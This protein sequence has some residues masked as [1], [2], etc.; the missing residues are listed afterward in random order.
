[1][2]LSVHTMSTPHL[3]LLKAIEL[4]A[5]IG[6]D[7]ID[8]ICDNDYRCA[9]TREPSFNRLKEIKRQTGYYGI[10]VVALTPYIKEINVADKKRRETAIAELQKCIDIAAEFDCKSIRI[11][12]GIEPEKNEWED[13]VNRLVESLQQL[14]EYAAKT[15]LSLNIENHSGSMAMTAHQTVQIVT[16]V[17]KENVGILYDPANLII[18]GSPDYRLSFKQQAEYIRHVHI[19]DDN[20]FEQGGYLPVLMGEGFI[21]WTEIIPLLKDSGY[22][23]FLSVEYEKRWHPEI[24]PDPRVGLRHEKKHIINL[25]K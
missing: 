25:I 2:K 3:D 8:L 17:N 21:P 6:F 10:P 22:D 4:Y 11:L 19:K 13:A 16:S 20:V 23:G 9:I 12:A 24:L 7:G 14:S 15:D 1:M 5:S 18:Y